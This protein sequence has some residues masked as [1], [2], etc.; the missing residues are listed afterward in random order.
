MAKIGSFKD[1]RAR[2]D[3]GRPSRAMDERRCAPDGLHYTRDEFREYFGGLTEWNAA[4]PAAKPA[5]SKLQPNAQ[6]FVPAASPA[7]APEAPPRPPPPQDAWS[8]FLPLWKPSANEEASASALPSDEAEANLDSQCD[9]LTAV[10]AIYERE[11][12]VVGGQTATADS[13][14]APAPAAAASELEP[15]EEPS[16]DPSAVIE[17]RVAIDADA[18]ETPPVARVNVPPALRKAIP[19]LPGEAAAEGDGATADGASSSSSGGSD[20]WPVDS[21]PPLVLRVRL[22]AAYPSQAS[23]VFGVRCAWLS[24]EQL[25]QLC[26]GLDTVCVES[27]GGPVICELVEWLR[28]EALRSLPD[29]PL[30][31]PLELPADETTAEAVAG[32]VEAVASRSARWPR[33]A[34]EVLSELVAHAQEASERAWRE[35]LHDCGICFDTC[36]SLDC[37][38]FFRCGHT[39][40][41]SCA[42]GYFGSLMADGAACAITC[43][44]PSCRLAVTPPEVKALLDAETYERF[45][46]LTVQS[47]LAGMKDIVW[48]PRCEYPAF[49]V[50]GEAGRL[51]LCGKCSFSFCKECNQS[52]HGLSPCANLATRW[53][54]AD[55]AG[56]AALRAKYGERV[57]EEVQSSEW[58]QQNTKPCPNC[59]THVEKN[60]GCNHITCRHCNFEWCWLCNCK[61]QPGHFRRGPGGC[62]Q[63]SQDFFDEIGMTQHDFEANFVVT[64]HW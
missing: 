60:G 6:S 51:A 38:R 26:N 52:W 21:L 1:T 54:N 56:R 17:L 53:R 24:D 30:S 63:F 58:M 57:L 15:I 12:R 31:R 41:R 13:E 14:H 19:R 23:P 7:P 37:V 47:S 61:Y 20:P 4:K 42:S 27:A 18:M 2:T 62:Q 8:A 46:K 48:C 34:P 44:E 5:A 32:A 29:S 28:T 35:A 25:V 43:P 64:N 39:F 11:L 33:S 59:Q 36:S 40:C 49:L 9:E 45:E 10:A 50:D 22:P 3:R 55:E 16:I